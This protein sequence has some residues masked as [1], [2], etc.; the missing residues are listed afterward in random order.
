MQL[1]SALQ[2]YGKFLPIK[3]DAHDKWYDC[4]SVDNYYRSKKKLLVSRYFNRIN[5]DNTV[6]M[7]IKKSRD[8]TKLKN[9]VNWNLSLPKKLKIL[10]PRIVDYLIS[11]KKNESFIS[12]E[13][14]GYPNLSEVWL[15][16]D[17][18]IDIWKSI[19]THLF[20]SYNNYSVN[21]KDFYEIYFKKTEDRFNNFLEKLCKNKRLFLGETI[22]INNTRY[23]NFNFLKYKIDKYIK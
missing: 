11:E 20:R 4:G 14:Y 18:N 2:Q 16:E 22:V 10:T 1:S 19:L 15:Y 6:G 7:L 12:M 3:A 17:L 5:V 21:K 13:Y 8:I 23:Y 9:E